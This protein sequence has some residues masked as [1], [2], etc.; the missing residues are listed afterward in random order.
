MFSVRRSHRECELLADC[1]WCC[2]QHGH[3]ILRV[4]EDI[5]RSDLFRIHRAVNVVVGVSIA[6]RVRNEGGLFFDVNQMTVALDHLCENGVVEVQPSLLG[7]SQEELRVVGIISPFGKGKDSIS[8]VLKVDVILIVEDT[9]IRTAAGCGSHPAELAHKAMFQPP[10]VA[11][12]VVA[13]FHQL[14]H[15]PGWDWRPLFKQFEH[16]FADIV[17]RAP[18]DSRRVAREA[19]KFHLHA[20]IVLE[21]FGGE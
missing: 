13:R 3:T 4:R 5:Y 9:Q 8:I 7:K 19:K 21:H 20:P 2:L 15:S 6:V 11:V 14:D 18:G 1:S 17:L 12:V 10:H 16:H